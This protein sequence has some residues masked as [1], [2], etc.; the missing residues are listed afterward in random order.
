MKHSNPCRVGPILCA[1]TLV[2][3]HCAAN[4]GEPANRI[5]ENDL[6]RGAESNRSQYEFDYVR[7][8]DARQ[9]VPPTPMPDKIRES[10][11]KM[12]N[13]QADLDRVWLYRQK[14][15]RRNAG[16][17][18]EKGTIVVRRFGSMVAVEKK[19]LARKVAGEDWQAVEAIAENTA[20][21]LALKGLKMPMSYKQDV[22]RDFSNGSLLSTVGRFGPS[23]RI[24]AD[25]DKEATYSFPSTIG[26]GVLAI[27]LAGL[28]L[29]KFVQIDRFGR[30]EGGVSWA[31]QEV[32][33]EG[34]K[35][36]QTFEVDASSGDLVNFTESVAKTPY[37][38]VD[39]EHYN[40]YPNGSKVPTKVD[41]KFRSGSLA[42]LSQQVTYT[43]KSAEFGDKVDVKDMTSMG[44]VGTQAQDNRLKGPK[45][46]PYVIGER[47]KSDAEVRQLAGQSFQHDVPPNNSPTQLLYIGT[48]GFLLFG[49]AGLAY[50]MRRPRSL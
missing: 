23:G 41:V 24:D 35:K 11:L 26:S 18:W 1:V 14:M 32:V 15:S 47:P 31:N 38:T 39:I 36:T 4:P 45:A 2:A 34:H 6:F 42:H 7:W 10:L 9:I 37:F 25:I 50:R 28:P 3:A 48:G 21:N 17:K 12:G 5:L 40:T 46:V 43:L 30:I 16:E 44:P 19:V 29:S 13:T 27:P 49:G 8:E 20:R 33:R 22:I